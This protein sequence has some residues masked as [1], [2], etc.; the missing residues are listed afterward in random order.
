MVGEREKNEAEERKKV[1]RG[2]HEA[3][4]SVGGWS[5]PICSELWVI[6]QNIFASYLNG[7][8]RGFP[9]NPCTHRLRATAG[10]L[11]LRHSW[12]FPDDAKGTLWPAAGVERRCFL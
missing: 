6:V 10:I 5:L 11:T 2:T 12:L 7:G 4:N 8:A 1:M 9:F 3:G